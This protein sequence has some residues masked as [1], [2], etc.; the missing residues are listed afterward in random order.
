[1]NSKVNL[2]DN[3]FHFNGKLSKKDF[4]KIKKHYQW[5]FNYKLIHIVG[6]NGKGSNSKYI[7]D[8]LILNGYNVGLFTSPHVIKMN[9]RIKI[10][11]SDIDDEQIND[12]LFTLK[13]DF[14]NLKLSWFDFFFLCSIN[15]FESNN[16]DIAIFE[17]GIGAKKD[18]VN[19]INYNFLLITSI[20]LEHENIL[21]NTIFKIANDKM[22]SIKNNVEVFIPNSIDDKIIKKFKTR[23]KNKKSKFNLIKVNKETFEKINISLSKSF[24]TSAFKIS[25]FKSDFSPPIGRV[26]NLIINN[27]SCYVDVAHNIESIKATLDFFKKKKIKFE[28]VLLSIS[29]DKNKKIFDIIKNEDF[30]KI[31]AYQNKGRKPLDLQEYDESFIK[32]DNLKSFI[33]NLDNKTLFIGSFHLVSEI[34]EEVYCNNK[35]QNN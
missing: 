6:T 27:I 34:L 17:S 18:V 32:V 31:Y 28:Q 11:N 8:E 10:N 9:E 19:Y 24:L 22:Y 12:F 3:I 5:K 14:K 30:K 25:N 33:N 16:I 1:M 29:L 15:Y 7:N 23:S 2:L 21:G 26:Q 35:K 4:N 20:S 13:K